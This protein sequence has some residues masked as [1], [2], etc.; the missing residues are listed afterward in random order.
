MSCVIFCSRDSHY[1]QEVEIKPEGRLLGLM[2]YWVSINLK[3]G[4]EVM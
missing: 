4:E 1:N 2:A 3:A